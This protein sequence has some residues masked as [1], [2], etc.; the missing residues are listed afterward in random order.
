M[1][2][3]DATSI[4]VTCTEDEEEGVWNRAPPVCGKTP[5]QSVHFHH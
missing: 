2:D 3:P 5:S 4:A 1:E